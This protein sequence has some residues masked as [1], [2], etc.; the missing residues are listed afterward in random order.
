MFLK[1][2]DGSEGLSEIL[3]LLEG[4]KPVRRRISPWTIAFDLPNR[5]TSGIGSM[6]SL[7]LMQVT[8]Q[9]LSNRVDL[10]QRGWIY[11]LIF[12]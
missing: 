9:R 8:I 12:G 2:L 6:R 5:F 4:C 11:S 1:A 3:S 7:M 10:V